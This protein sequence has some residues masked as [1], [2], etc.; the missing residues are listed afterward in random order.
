M[1]PALI[2]LVA[3]GLFFASCKSKPPK[4]AQVNSAAPADSV[5]DYSPDS[6]Q[7]PEPFATPSVKY[8]SDVI[9]WQGSTRPKAPEGFTVTL[10]ADQL[11]N[12]RWAYQSPDGTIFVSEANSTKS[13]T[14]KIKDAV[15]GKSRS[16][17]TGSANRIT[18]FRD[19][20]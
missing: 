19:A 1:K 8:Y 10:F 4:E 20:D 16:M 15:T 3:V 14:E 2:L 17:N 11:D 7:L 9:G 13:A 6:L 12:P 18:I 5:I